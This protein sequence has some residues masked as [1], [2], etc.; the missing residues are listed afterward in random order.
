MAFCSVIRQ[1]SRLFTPVA[2]LDALL[3]VHECKRQKHEL[4]H[5]ISADKIESLLC[6]LLLL[7]EQIT[8][9]IVRTEMMRVAWKSSSA[10][11]LSWL[12]APRS[13]LTSSMRLR[14]TFEQYSDLAK[15]NLTR[16]SHDDFGSA[17]HE[18]GKDIKNA[19]AVWGRKSSHDP[20][21]DS[22]CL[23]TH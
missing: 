20:T 2:E 16:R 17:Y 21:C 5:R 4:S 3:I 14:L 11:P 6:V 1:R 19:L 22:I 9:L 7:P 23:R 10:V 15:L 12:T 18:S 8:V 13:F